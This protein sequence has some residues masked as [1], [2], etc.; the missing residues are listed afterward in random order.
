MTNT[1]TTP[2]QLRTAKEFADQIAKSERSVRRL[3]EQRIVPSYKIGGS[4]R[5]D[6]SDINRYIE[7]GY[8]S[9]LN[10]ADWLAS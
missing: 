1:M 7:G 5:F 2:R 4:L 6:Q 9:P 3:A 8:L 10:P